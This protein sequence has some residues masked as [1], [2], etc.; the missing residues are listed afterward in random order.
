VAFKAEVPEQCRELLTQLK[1]RTDALARSLDTAATQGRTR[2]IDLVNGAVTASAAVISVRAYALARDDRIPADATAL[3]TV[4]FRDRE[5][6]RQFCPTLINYLGFEGNLTAIT[7]LR[8][9]S[10]GQRKE[11]VPFIWQI[12]AGTIPRDQVSCELLAKRYDLESA[13]QLRAAARKRVGRPLGE[14]AYIVVTR[15]PGSAIVV[16]DLTDVPAIDYERWL[17]MT[18]AGLEEEGAEE[19]ADD[20]VVQSGLRDVLRYYLFSATPTIRAALTAFMPNLGR[21]L[22]TGR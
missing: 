12:T 16:Y 13:R 18:V 19:P 21:M 6:A 22:G 9:A 3:A 15:L 11:I 10:E 5:Q 8:V 7:N 1:S 17:A 2:T 14:G 20:T 4:L